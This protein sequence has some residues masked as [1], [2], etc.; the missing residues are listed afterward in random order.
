MAEKVSFNY[1]GHSGPNL[2]GRGEGPPPPRPGDAVPACRSPDEPRSSKHL[3]RRWTSMVPRPVSPG[4][5]SGS[6]LEGAA[7]LPGDGGASGPS[8]CYL[9]VALRGAGWSGAARERPA[10]LNP[11]R[12]KKLPAAVPEARPQVDPACRK[13][14]PC[15][16]GRLPAD[17]DRCRRE[18]S[19]STRFGAT[20]GTGPYLRFE[21]QLVFRCG[22]GPLGARTCLERAL[23]GSWGAGTRLPADGS[24]HWEGLPE[25][26]R[27]C[28][29]ACRFR[30]GALGVW[31]RGGVRAGGWSKDRSGAFRP[32]PLA[33]DAGG[34]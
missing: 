1:L 20:P 13:R 4:G 30:A 26:C 15:A 5:W 6:L 17:D 29:G 8:G 25:P 27:R 31:G 21:N 32:G 14:V 11:P 22:G 34:W 9:A 3:P 19:F 10:L 12:K 23:A 33:A 7:H 18:A 16:G 24:V 28:G 2:G